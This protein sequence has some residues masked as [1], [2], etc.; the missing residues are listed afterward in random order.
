MRALLLLSA[1]VLIG[2]APPQKPKTPS[3]IVAQAPAS[4]WRDIDP[5]DLL[6]MDLGSGGRVVIQLAP[7]FAPV[8]VA[9]IRA[10]AKGSWWTGSTIYRVQD[11][12]VVQWGNNEGKKPLPTGVVA[13]PPAEYHRA[14][15]G[16]TVRPLGY[17]DDYAPQAGYA[18]GWPVG[19]DAKAGTANLT[20]CYGYVGV[21]RDLSP[22]TGTGGELYA[23]IGHAPRHLD[24]N[25]AV[26]GRVIE[27][28]ERMSSLPRGTEALGF[29]KSERQNVPISMVRLG[30]EIPAAE[31]PAF[32]VMDTN[33]ATFAAYLRGRA[34]RNDDF[35]IRPAGG[36]D[37]CNAP[38][39]IRRKPS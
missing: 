14:L 2:A 1:A 5:D 24:R 10:L 22:D 29:Y 7:E 26:V 28:I 32:Q 13:K 20:H 39:P 27:G 36:V 33:S 34:N 16:L 37:L 18:S 23:V 15:K 11:N 21:G 8:H 17:P 4:V 31:R 19:Y 25:I 9:N 30:S 35:F 6:V 3:E 12:Y 38:V